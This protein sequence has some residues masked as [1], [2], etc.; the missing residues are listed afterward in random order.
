MS[1]I[2]V[3]AYSLLTSDIMPANVTIMTLSTNLLLRPTMITVATLNVR[4]ISNATV[5]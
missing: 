4:A 5:L 2:C 3:Y 1:N